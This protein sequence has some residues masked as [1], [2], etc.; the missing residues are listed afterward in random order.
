MIPQ[1]RD[2]RLDQQLTDHDRLADALDEKVAA[3]DM[4]R[5]A[6]RLALRSAKLDEVKLVVN[7]E[8]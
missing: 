1:V 6:L 3:L 2:T 7:R 4:L 5:A 8:L